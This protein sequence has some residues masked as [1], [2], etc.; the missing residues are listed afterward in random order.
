MKD[1]ARG[2]GHDDAD[3]EEQ[4][5]IPGAYIDGDDGVVAI[6]THVLGIRA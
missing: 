4:A 2:V 5:G 6:V 3:V 1:Q